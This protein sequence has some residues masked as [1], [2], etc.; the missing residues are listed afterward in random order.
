M[1]AR[2]GL[3]RDLFEGRQS[4][5]LRS[6]PASSIACAAPLDGSGGRAHRKNRT[7]RLGRCGPAKAAPVAACG[8]P[9]GRVFGIAKTFSPGACPLGARDVDAISA[10]AIGAGAAPRRKKHARARP[11]K[12]ES[13]AAATNASRRGSYGRCRRTVRRRHRRARSGSPSTWHTPG[14]HHRA[15]RSAFEAGVLVFGEDRA[16]GRVGCPSGSPGAFELLLSGP[17]IGLARRR[18]A[19]AQ[20]GGLVSSAPPTF[21]SFPYTGRER[22]KTMGW[23]GLAVAARRLAARA[24]ATGGGGAVHR[25]AEEGAG[26]TPPGDGRARGRCSTAAPCCVSPEGAFA[27]P[28]GRQGAGHR[29]GA[30]AGRVR[31]DAGEPRAFIGGPATERLPI[32][33]ARGLGHDQASR[34]W[35]WR[36]RIGTYETLDRGP[37]DRPGCSLFVPEHPRR[38]RAKARP[39]SESDSKAR[40]EVKRHGRRSMATAPPPR[41]ADLARPSR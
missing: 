9:R 22:R 6:A 20:S 39:P 4:R 11:F 29:R 18:L 5:L 3:G 10:V 37:Y 40:L 12:V 38:T 32:A 21:H 36:K 41:R 24:R 31:Q 2:P 33:A 26:A 1:C 25:R 35:R 19:D 34:R 8:A 15:S 23:R 14:V 17:A 16:R 27:P 13:R 28:L 7:A 30:G